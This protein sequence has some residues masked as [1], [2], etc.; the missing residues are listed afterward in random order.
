MTCIE[1][2][3]DTSITEKISWAEACY[4]KYKNTFLEDNEVRQLL[5]EFRKASS[6]SAKEM[7]SIGLVDECR[8]CEEEEGGACC[9]K[10][11][12]NRYS[13]TLLLINLL[14]GVTLPEDAPDDK[15]CFFLCKKGC[16]LI[17][18]HTICL[19][20]IC[21]KI[22]DRIPAHTLNQLREK[23]GKELNTLFIL[24]EKVKSILKNINE[25]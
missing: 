24:N 25:C 13:G 19:N 22:T 5:T 1:I 3:P 17:A 23:E 4:K 16:S 21:K 20:Y 18:R 2:S 14:L 9:G 12:E 6:E 10:G 7:V 11:I 8:K 15:S